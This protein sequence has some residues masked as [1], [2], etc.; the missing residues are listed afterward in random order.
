MDA[1]NN[2]GKTVQQLN[3][4]LQHDHLSGFGPKK[5]LKKLR[6]RKLLKGRR[7]LTAS[8]LRMRQN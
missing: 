7:G 4:I 8:P 2:G 5:S 1:Q 3:T 6:A